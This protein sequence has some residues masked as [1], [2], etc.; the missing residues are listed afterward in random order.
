MITI[1]EPKG[2]AKEYGDY[3]LNIYTGC[4]HRCFYCVDENA[5]VLT[6]ELRSVPIKDIKIGDKVLGVE[7]DGKYQRITVATVTNKFAS[8][9]E[10]YKVRLEDGTEIICSADHRWL[11]ARRGWKY[12]VGA[13]SGNDQRPYLTKQ[14]K[15]I[16]YGKCADITISKETKAYKRGYLYGII[17]GDGTI[18]HYDYPTGKRHSFRLAMNE[19]VAV[20]RT[21]RYLSDFGIKTF[22]FMFKSKDKAMPAIRASGKKVFRI[23]ELIYPNKN[24]KTDSEYLRGFMAGF[25]DAEGNSCIPHRAYNTNKKLL[26]LYEKALTA[27]G[28]THKREPFRGGKNNNVEIVHLCGGAGEAIRFCQ[29]ADVAIRN[30]FSIIN[31]ALKN[32]A[33]TNVVSIEALNVEKKMIDITT[34]TGNFIAYGCV[35]HN[36]FA[37]NVLHRDRK[38][39]HTEV[40]PRENIIEETKHYIES[41]GLTGKLVHLCFTCDPYPTG[42]DTAPTREIIKLLKDSGN[43]V[44]ILTKGD[45]SGDFDLLD[46]NDWYG[47]TLD[48]S[49][50]IACKRVEKLLAAHNRG[51]KTWVSFEPVVNAETVLAQIETVAPFTDKVKIGKLN[52]HKSDINWKEFGEKAEA[53]CKKLGLNYY[54]KDA[55]RKEMKKGKAGSNE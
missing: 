16:G 50:G 26:A 37:P 23:E 52:Y 14:S 2:A 47:I 43:H 17:S 6:P 12:T 54:I 21:Q 41:T 30:K 44:Q 34:T 9:K 22:S 55:L 18:G 51:I 36:C 39:F 20:E 4:P 33:K 31:V 10:A 42:Y 25:Y 40:K 15:I 27:F 28:F 46:E 45:G 49:E 7:F 29:I 38:V 8:I 24:D 19:K 3:A 13:M 1:Y 48:G 35:A 5:P 53:L 32:K 11:T